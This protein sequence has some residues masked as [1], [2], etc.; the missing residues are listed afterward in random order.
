MPLK[1]SYSNIHYHKINEGVFDACL[2]KLESDIE[3]TN[4][5]MLAK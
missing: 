4:V 1:Y 2:S 3:F 5:N